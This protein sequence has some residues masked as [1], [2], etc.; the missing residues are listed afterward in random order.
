MDFDC[1]DFGGGSCQDPTGITS[2]FEDSEGLGAGG[3][4][5]DQFPEGGSSLAGQASLMG[6]LAWACSGFVY[7]L[8]VGSAI[9]W[10]WA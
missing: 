6:M 7:G 10:H 2:G 9:V 1:G 3:A 4:G 5:A 8:Y